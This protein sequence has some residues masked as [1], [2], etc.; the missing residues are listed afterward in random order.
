M[1]NTTTEYTD[2][3]HINIR[4]HH[5]PGDDSVGMLE[6]RVHII[7][8]DDRE[9]LGNAMRN[10]AEKWILENRMKEGAFNFNLKEKP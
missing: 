3:I 5:E 9:A 10:A 4:F 2:G 8:K 7:P 6:I 1:A